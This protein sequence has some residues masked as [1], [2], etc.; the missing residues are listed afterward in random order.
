MTFQGE[1]DKIKEFFHISIARYGLSNRFIENVQKKYPESTDDKQFYFGNPPPQENPRKYDFKTT[2]SGFKES[3]N[4]HKK[5][6]INNCIILLVSSWYLYCDENNIRKY[7]DD[8]IIE[9]ILYRNCIVHNDGIIDN[10]YIRT[11]RLQK[12][13]IG[14]KLDFSEEDF[15]EFLICFEGK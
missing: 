7:Y 13:Q 9:V 6:L 3:L 11:S 12:Y 1:L 2:I 15:K 8:R 5:I 4:E 10:K 14:E